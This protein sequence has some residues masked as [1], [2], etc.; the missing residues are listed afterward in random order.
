M[1]VLF[2]LPGFHKVERGAETALLA[3][4]SELATRGVNVTVFGSGNA[5]VGSAYDFRHV[6][7]IPRTCFQ[8]YPSMPALRNE[9][10][11]EDLTF[12]LTLAAHFRPGQFDL[13]V[14]CNYPHTNWMLRRPVPFRR[15]PQHIFVTQNGD[16]PAVSNESEFRYFGCDGL[17][18]TN[19]E[20]FERNKNVWNSALIPNGVDTHRFCPGPSIRGKLNIPAGTKTILMV[21][22]LVESKRVMQGITAAAGL[23]HAHLIIAGSGPLRDAVHEHAKHLM[24]GR[25]T[26]LTLPAEEMP[27]LYN[28]ADAL[29]HLSIEESFGNIFVEAMA[30]GIPIVAHDSSRVRWIVGDDEYLVDSLDLSA[31]TVALAKA[32][33][34]KRRPDHL[35]AAK[36]D[37]FKWKTIGAD[38]HRF[39]NEV[40]ST[41]GSVA[42]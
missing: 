19:P 16:W 17:V 38:Y 21:S 10:S 42:R 8:R 25:F 1:R 32:V 12:A 26:Q 18:C 15:R 31:V 20:Y 22:A 29:M 13:T 37:R 39:F 24:P 7:A 4:A 33:Q 23:E 14:T 5:R 3:V 9:T 28:S 36:T 41:A 30:T 34:A 2:A 6:G 11:Y 27:A 35:I 40:L